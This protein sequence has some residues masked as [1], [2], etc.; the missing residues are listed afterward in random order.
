MPVFFY[1]TLGADTAGE[2]VLRSVGGPELQ[3]AD[4]L[5]DRRSGPPLAGRSV[6][7]ATWRLRP[8]AADGLCPTILDEG[9][10]DDADFPTREGVIAWVDGTTAVYLA[11][12]SI[13]HGPAARDLDAEIVEAAEHSFFAPRG[14]AA[15]SFEFGC[16]VPEP[17]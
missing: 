10:P 17:L 14:P 11:C 8:D 13:G 1:P 6:R 3:V 2:L 16:D 15:R 12:R 9:D 4:V 7:W 5:V